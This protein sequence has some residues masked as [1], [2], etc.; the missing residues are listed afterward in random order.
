MK[1]LFV[2]QSL[3]KGGAERLV[4]E[5]TH[6]IKKDFPQ[7]EVKIISLDRQNDFTS[8]SQGLDIEY[9]NSKVQLSIT[10]K[11]KIDIKEYEEI[12]DRYQPDVI[13]S[14]TYKAELVSRENPRYG[15]KYFTHVHGPFSEFEPFGLKTLTSKVSYV[16]LYERI[17]ILKRYRKINN[18]FIT[19]SKSIDVKFRDQLGRNWHNNIRLIPNAINFMKFNS[20]PHPP[21]NNNIELISVGRMFPIKNH[22]YLLKVV[23]ELKKTAPGHNWR[24]IIAG[25]GPLKAEM[26]KQI[27]ELDLQGKVSLPGKIESVEMELKKSHIYV[28]SAILEPFGLTILEAMAASLPVVCLDGGGNRDFIQNDVNGYILDQKTTPEVFAKKIIDMV[29]DPDEYTRIT[30]AANKTAQQY[31][32]HNYIIELIAL[33]ND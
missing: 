22:M 18:K 24:L 7:I 16:R 2:T 26:E 11:S 12:V 10:R 31:D 4:L 29:S 23:D 13:H 28:H 32:I 3:G 33:Y 25:N 19:I 30:N 5:I 1:I 14:H 15:I 8:L 6:A 17:R 21:D 20:I 27:D 9:C